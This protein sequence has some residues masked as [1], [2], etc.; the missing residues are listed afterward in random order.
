MDLR[1][2]YQYAFYGSFHWGKDDTARYG[3][4]YLHDPIL[5]LKDS[6]FFKSHINYA[7]L[8]HLYTAHPVSISRRIQK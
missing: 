3:K 2:L 5:E 6:S 8:L 7:S 1:V 4:Y